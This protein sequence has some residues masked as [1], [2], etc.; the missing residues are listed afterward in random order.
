MRKIYEIIKKKH[1]LF[2][3]TKNKD[4]IR[5][6]QEIRFLKQHV[7]LY[8]EIVFQEK[9]Y[10]IR[11]FKVLLDCCKGKWKKADVVF[12]G[13]APQLLL[14]FL[15]RWKKE[16]IIIIDF[17]VS[18]Y[19]T[20]VCDRKYFKEKSFI[21][22]ILHWIDEKTVKYCDRIIAD[23]YA[24]AQYFSKE[25]HV[26]LNKIAVYYL[27]ADTSIYDIKRYNFKTKDSIM[28]ILY[29][30]SILPL[31]GVDVILDSIKLLQSH[32]DIKFTIIGPMRKK[33]KSI[34]KEYYPNVKFYN[35]LPQEELAKQ[36]AQSDLC[37]AGHFSADIEKAKRTI[38]GKAY[39]YEA[40]GKT[41]ILGDNPANREL[42]PEDSKHIF[43]KM[44]DPKDLAKKI[45][46]VNK[47][48][49]E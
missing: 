13:F 16:K 6:Q 20:F 19:D 29:F 30:G 10:L 25:F 39:I 41:M 44:G 47:T 24:D 26:T 23:T 34:D 21:A 35:W 8:E 4:Y 17:F 31:Q 11:I 46:Q 18:L 42:F 33:Q 37:L 9:Y 14:P 36:I 45:K 32:T 22:K 7:T 38:P 43:V 49:Y 2:I 1:V 27:E 48:R 12:A 28:S 3:S 5:N 40:M 15:F